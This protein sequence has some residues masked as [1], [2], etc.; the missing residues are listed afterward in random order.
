MLQV[1][2]NTSNPVFFQALRE[3]ADNYFKS[4]KLSTKGDVRLYTKTVV[5]T[6]SF[7]GIYVGLVFFTPTSTLFSLLLCGLLGANFA[8]IGFNVMHD[9]AHGSYS[10]T[11]WLNESMGFTLNIMGG[12]MYLWKQK[13]NENHHT[14]TN[15][16]GMDDDIDLKP[17]LRMHKDQKKIWLH[18]YQ[19]FYGVF[20]YGLTLVFWAYIRD[21]K[22]YFSGKIAENT[23][24]RKMNT[25][26]HFI[27]WISKVIHIS[28]FLVIPMVVV[29]VT[30]TLI[31]YATMAYVCGV[32]LSVVFQ[33]AH[34]VEESEFVVPVE[35]QTNVENEWAIHQ[36]N[37]TFN[38]ATKNKVVGWL[39]GGLN[40]QVEHHLFPRV[41][42][43][44]YPA[45]SKI[46]KQ[47]CEEY[48]VNY[49][50]FPTVM[51]AF[52]SHLMHLKAVGRA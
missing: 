29:G 35:K 12:N 19:H 30:E 26:D 11:K 48:S 41:S 6:L 17:F 39:L 21:F 13:H 18:R 15:V 3:R 4:N 27:F 20:L 38:F 36:V 2:F 33:L 16:E 7:I 1:R 5:L 47:T 8:A 45:L 34:V 49:K 43:V 14:F 52:Q 46:V 23:K 31:G 28:L 50:E 42:H 44:H 25:R 51:V 37:T 9:G 10:D 22:K 40:F 32:I 24:M